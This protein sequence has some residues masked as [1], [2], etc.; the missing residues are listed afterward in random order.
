MTYTKIKQKKLITPE[1][2]AVLFPTIISSIIVLIVF[3]AFVIPKFINS[4]RVY[5]EVMEFL[6]KKD[7]LP[8]LKL[9]ALDIS[10]KLEKL[11]TEKYKILNL[12]SG[13]TNLDT[14]LNRLDLLALNNDIK[15]VSII[16]KTLIKFVET[17][18]NNNDNVAP[19]I[20]FDSDD[21]LVEGLKKNII[22]VNL[23][24]NFSNLLSFLN[25]IEFQE[26][27]ILMRNIKI[28]PFENERVSDKK[29]DANLLEVSLE[30]I[31]Y[32]KI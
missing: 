9:Q 26:N 16:P 17:E 30:M 3:S 15:V 20:N 14:F 27:V 2:A 32:G 29:N 28:N 13:D 4:N 6:R 19:N 5:F 12:I 8:N 31:I 10:N 21:L 25:D 11:N 7:D 18:G 24:S 1:R 23:I 22:D